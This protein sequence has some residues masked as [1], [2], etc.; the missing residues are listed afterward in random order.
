M[1]G[2]GSDYKDIIFISTYDFYN[3]I[4]GMKN[5]FVYIKDVCFS[6]DEFFN[7]ILGEMN[8]ASSFFPFT[9]VA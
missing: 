4:I 3:I 1:L 8:T 7:I 2:Y 5:V 9:F 6:L